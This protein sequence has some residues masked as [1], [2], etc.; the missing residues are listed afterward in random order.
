MRHINKTLSRALVSVRRTVRACNALSREQEILPS[1]TECSVLT[2]DVSGGIIR[3]KVEG[4]PSGLS[5]DPA[6]ALEG[7]R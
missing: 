7:Q 2:S 3:H 6:L 1:V 4:E 5:G